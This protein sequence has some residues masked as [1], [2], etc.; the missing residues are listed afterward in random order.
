MRKERILILYRRYIGE[1]VRFGLVG[2]VSAGCLYGVYYI[3]L[4]FINPTLSY[5]IGYFISFLLNYALSICFTFKVKSKGVKILGFALSHVINYTLQV[6]LLN[7]V[8]F[9]GCSKKIAPIPVLM[10]CIPT[11]FLLVRYF[12][13]KQ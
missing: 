7:F 13:K 3:L 4:Q 8:I 6:L 5:S 1:I 11:N 2:I 12:L 9:L 10:V